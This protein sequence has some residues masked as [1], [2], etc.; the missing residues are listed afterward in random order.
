MIFPSHTY[1]GA[2]LSKR[3][4]WHKYIEFVKEKAWSRMNLLRLLRMLKF[5]IDSK[6]LETIYFVYI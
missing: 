5:Q 3:C 6:S 2:Y 4:D 1:L